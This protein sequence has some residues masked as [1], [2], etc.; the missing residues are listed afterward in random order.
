VTRVLIVDD[1]PVFLTALGML[2]EREGFEVRT[3]AGA[4]EALELAAPFA[5]DVLIV[6]WLLRG[7][8]DGVDVAESLRRA[9]Q[10]P[11]LILITGHATAELR[12]RLAARGGATL[13]EKPFSPEELVVAVRKHAAASG[14]P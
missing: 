9:G 6:D 7:A 11:Q 4:Q 13:L 8:A 12:E 1:E 10:S 14:G 2:L 5:P 3:A